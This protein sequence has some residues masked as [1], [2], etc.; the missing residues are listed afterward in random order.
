M[1]WSQPASEGIMA[2][3]YIGLGL[4]IT[5]PLLGLMQGNIYI[6][7]LETGLNGAYDLAL[8]QD[9]A[10]RV[11]WSSGTRFD[12]QISTTCSTSE[13]V[14][15]Q[16]RG[17]ADGSREVLVCGLAARAIEAELPRSVSAVY[18]VRLRVVGADTPQ[19]FQLTAVEPIP[20]VERGFGS[21]GVRPV[22]STCSFN[23]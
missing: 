13:P 8:I 14:N 9:E 21:L 17:L 10:K 22:Q 15:L 11:L 4:A 7:S 2:Y 1:A 16:C 19:G 5:L 20:V 3:L 6:Y 23:A 18:D 12:P